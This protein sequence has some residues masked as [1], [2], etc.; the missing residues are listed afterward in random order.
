M[1]RLALYLLGPPRIECDGTAVQIRRRKAVALLA[2]LAVAGPGPVGS[3]HSREKLATLLWPESDQS[4]ALASLRVALVALNNALGEGWLAVDREIVGL[5]PDI[6]PSTADTLSASRSA[7]GGA[8][9]RELW[10][11]MHEFQSRLAACRSHGHPLE[12]VCPACISALAEAVALYRDDFLAGF[13][14]PDSPTYDE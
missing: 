3:S 7:L 5:N 6:A 2:Y 11:D 9:G 8:L 10:L 13:T 14:L 12:E 1:S 4:R